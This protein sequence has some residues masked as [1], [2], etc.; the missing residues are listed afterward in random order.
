MCST[1]TL[2]SGSAE[3]WVELG[4]LRCVRC[5]KQ[6]ASFASADILAVV[7]AASCAFSWA[8]GTSTY[9]I[10]IGLRIALFVKGD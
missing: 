4:I 9:K 2:G 5:F 1:L 3:L 7:S 10:Q 8:T 6:S